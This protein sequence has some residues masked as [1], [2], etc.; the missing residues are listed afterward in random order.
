[1]FF[2]EHIGKRLEYAEIWSVDKQML[3]FSHGQSCVEIGFS[4]N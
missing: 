4:E 3:I 2:V 1:M